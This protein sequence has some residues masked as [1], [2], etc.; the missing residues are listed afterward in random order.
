MENTPIT[1]KN[2]SI[3]EKH[4]S[5]ILLIIQVF[6]AGAEAYKKAQLLIVKNDDR[7]HNE[8][9]YCARAMTSIFKSI[10]TN[11]YDENF[12]LALDDAL[13][14]SRHI[15]ND[16]LDFIVS[17]AIQESTKANEIAKFSS[18][19]DVRKDYPEIRK[20]MKS[21]KEKI[22][23]SR[24]ER[25]LVRIDEYIEMVESEQYKK[26]IDYCDDIPDIV[27]ELKKKKLNEYQSSRNW[28]I[29]IAIALVSLV[30]GSILK[31]L[32]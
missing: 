25:G 5:R 4:T 30:V 19:I 28:V 17:Y 15:L 16:C 3:P 14:A 22:S 32:N 27:A 13:N 12:D 23:L 6:D 24:K 8:F 11:T 10:C 20:I 26:L 31:I 7:I 29:G 18:I 9:A 1:L 2:S 21:F